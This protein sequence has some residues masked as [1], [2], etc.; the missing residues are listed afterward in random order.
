MRALLALLVLSLFCLAPARAYTP[1]SGLWWNPAE[2]GVGYTFDLQDNFMGMTMYMYSPGGEPDWYIANGFLQGNALFEGTVMRFQDGMCFGCS[3][4]RNAFDRNMGSVRV[5]FNA[6]DSTRATM[7]LGGRTFPIE[8]Y[9]FYLKR[10]EDGNASIR[11]TKM[12][13][14]WSSTIDLSSVAAAG[15]YPFSGDILVFDL[16]DLSEA[17]GYFEGCRPDDGVVAFCSEDALDFHGAAGFFDTDDQRH[18]IVVDDSADFFVMYVMQV[19]TDTMRGTM[20]VYRK[21]TEPTQ[22]FPVRGFRTASRTF[23]E[24]GVGP[25]K[26]TAAAAGER[27]DTDTGLG[28]LLEGMGA[29]DKVAS[30]DLLPSGDAQRLTQIRHALE[31]RLSDAR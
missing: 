4:S 13:G 30:T 9:Q 6:N 10:P 21:G 27:K 18:V 28:A 5:V 20:S 24:E 25:A 22:F 7:T 2:S 29:F 23:V 15:S 1:E 26:R 19:G 31:Q 12:L 14:E 11:L 3:W 16:I 17:P 8:R